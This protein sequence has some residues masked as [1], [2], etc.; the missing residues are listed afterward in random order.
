M[1]QLRFVAGD[2]PC[3]VFG[4]TF[5]PGEWVDCSTLAPDVVATLSANPTFQYQPDPTADD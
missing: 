4:V 5:A 1:A 2:E 3:A